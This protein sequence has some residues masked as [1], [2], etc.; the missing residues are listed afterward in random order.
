MSKWDERW[1]DLEE[2]DKAHPEVYDKLVELARERKALGH[3]RYGFSVI[4]GMARW[5]LQFD[6]GETYRMN[7]D[8]AAVYARAIMRDEKDLTGFFETRKSWADD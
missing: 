6:S 5:E 4:W 3:T 8:Y 7:N 1:K 2:Y